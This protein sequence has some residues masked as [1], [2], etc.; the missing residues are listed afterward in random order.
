MDRKKNL[1]VRLVN[2][3]LL[4]FLCCIGI[5]N[6]QA[7]V[8]YQKMKI[9]PTPCAVI[10]NQLDRSMVE[11]AKDENRFENH[12]YLIIIVR[13]GK[14]ESSRKLNRE[15]IS[16]LRKFFE[17]RR[18]TKNVIFAEGQKSEVKLGSGE[19]YI[20]GILTER[21]YFKYQKSQLCSSVEESW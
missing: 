11:F 17:L 19:V 21:F 18:Q 13:A 6:G 12:K 14:T 4:K 5:G 1:A 16:N 2:L 15:R 10:R 20:N 8:N 9:E 7:I 3:W